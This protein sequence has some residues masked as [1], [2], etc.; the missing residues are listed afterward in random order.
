[1]REKE[2]EKKRKKMKEMEVKKWKRFE[3]I[4]E[5]RIKIKKRLNRVAVCLYS[6]LFDDEEYLMRNGL[7]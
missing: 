3:K 2:I 5:K 1:M 4:E 7:A 6:I